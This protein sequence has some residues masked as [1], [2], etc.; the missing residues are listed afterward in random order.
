MSYPSITSAESQNVFKY[1]AA[2]CVPLATKSSLLKPEADRSDL[3]MLPIAERK[4]EEHV[5]IAKEHGFEHPTQMSMTQPPIRCT[6]AKN[7][8]VE[9]PM[10]IDEPMIFADEFDDSSEEC[11]IEALLG[12]RIN[13]NRLAVTKALGRW[14][15]AMSF[16]AKAFNEDIIEFSGNDSFNSILLNELGGFLLKHAQYKARMDKFRNGL[17]KDLNFSQL[18]RNK[19]NLIADVF[20]YLNSQYARRT[21]NSS[22]LDPATS[23]PLAASRVKATFRDEPGE[24][25]GVVR[26]FYAAFAEAISDMTHLPKEGDLSGSS[27]QIGEMK[28][29]DNKQLDSLPLFCR[30]SKHGFLA[31]I[32]GSNSSN[33]RSA[34]RN[35]GR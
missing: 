28:K 22:G 27:S 21:A 29:T 12:I 34:F 25:S 5:N 11:N 24:G 4:A 17:T 20:G 33:R 1:S 15:N 31:P 3:F 13:S 18:T 26:S 19:H 2:E 10:Q 8:E 16:M 32:P 23:P 6:H 7:V 9:E 14:G 35:V 30:I